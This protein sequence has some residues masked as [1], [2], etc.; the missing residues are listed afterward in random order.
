MKLFFTTIILFLFITIGKSQS[1]DTITELLLPDSLNQNFTDFYKSR[2]GRLFASWGWNRATYAKSSI[3]FVGNGYDFTIK[4][5]VAKDKPEP[6]N[7][8]V[9]FNPGLLSIPQYNFRIGYFITNKLSLTLN[10]DHMKYVFD[11]TQ[12]AVIDGRIESSASIKYA[13]TYENEE[14]QFTKDF[15]GYEHTDGLNVISVELDYHDLFYETKDKKFAIDLVAGVGLG[16]TVPKT[17]AYLFGEFGNDAFHLAGGGISGNA[18][19]KLYFFKHF[20]LHPTTKFGYLMMPNV[21][22]NGLE[23]DRASQNISFF[24]GNFTIG[25]QYKIAHL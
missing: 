21:A 3:H 20:F 6:F 23:I 13:K 24:Q 18:G 5:A 1:Q 22:T 7:W 10:V 14:V 15:I 8:N 4:K 9:Y 12:K 2:K 25:F 17:N 16:A 19:L 11:H